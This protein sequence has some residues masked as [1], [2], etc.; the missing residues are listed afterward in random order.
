[1]LKPKVHAF[2]QRYAELHP[3]LLRG[4]HTQ[5]A[6]QAARVQQAQQVSSIVMCVNVYVILI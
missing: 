3:G 4:K 1:M 2:R 6:Q 5:Q